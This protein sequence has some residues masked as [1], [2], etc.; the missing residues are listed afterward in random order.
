MR[1]P[2]GGADDARAVEQHVPVEETAAEPRHQPGHD[3][4][5]GRLADAG[6]AGDEDQLALVDGE[7]DPV[8]DGIG[9][10]VVPEGDAAC[11]LDHVATSRVRRGG[12]EHSGPSRATRRAPARP[13]DRWQR[14]EGRAGDVHLVGAQPPAEGADGDPRRDDRE[15]G[16]SARVGPVAGAVDAATGAEQAG[17]RDGDPRTSIGSASTRGAVV[18]STA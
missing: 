11:Q 10:V 6:G 2:R 18:S 17:D 7:V 16:A 3:P 9:P 1:P 13:A 4:E 15:L 5:Q 8:E 12:G 14:V